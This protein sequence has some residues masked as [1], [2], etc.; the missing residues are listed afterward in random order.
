MVLDLLHRTFR[1]MMMVPELHEKE[2]QQL[3]APHHTTLY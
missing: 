3:V 2:G 1:K